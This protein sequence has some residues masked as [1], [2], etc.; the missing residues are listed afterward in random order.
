MNTT[1]NITSQVIAP[2]AVT[3]KVFQLINCKCW[4]WN[5]SCFD[6]SRGSSTLIWGAPS[7]VF[8]GKKSETGFF[9]LMNVIEIKTILR[10]MELPT[11]LDCSIKYVL[12]SSRKWSSHFSR[13][14]GSISLWRL[15]VFFC[16]FCNRLE[17]AHE[18]D[19]I[20]GLFPEVTGGMAT[21]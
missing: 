6:K 9:N 5:L 13:S 11:C 18:N 10:T 15:R 21:G 2:T 19:V 4:S 17:A 12:A 7:C 14:T 20:L 1:G 8:G 16:S 3:G